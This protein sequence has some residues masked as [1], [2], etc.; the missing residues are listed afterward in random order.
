LVALKPYAPA[1][2]W[3]LMT[4]D[5]PGTEEYANLASNLT[6]RVLALAEWW[7]SGSFDSF[8]KAMESVP[9]PVMVH[10]DDGYA[11]A[12]LSLALATKRGAQSASEV[13]DTGRS[14]G[15]DFV[16]DDHALAVLGRV[17]AVPSRAQ[18]P[19][20]NTLLAPGGYRSYYKLKRYSDAWYVGGQPNVTVDLHSLRATGIKVVVNFRVPGEDDA[21]WPGGK[22]DEGAEAQAMAAAGLKYY[23]LGIEEPLTGQELAR[24][25]RLLATAR[26]AAG[27]SPV[28]V[29]CRTGARASA[30]L[31][32][33]EAVEEERPVSWI[34][35]AAD[36]LGYAF[37]DSAKAGDPAV[38]AWQDL[39]DIHYMLANVVF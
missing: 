32:G 24:A 3:N 14:L 5:F 30:A 35:R 2:E 7:Q 17:A 39:L 31:L 21:Y 25:S 23:A 34:L 38:K 8:E 11:S 12:A 6:V 37:W 13:L 10:C 33:H 4:S 22:Y 20:L 36:Q 26:A 1:S 15:F 28:F 9:K 16:A 27:D 18:S 19:Q 29:H